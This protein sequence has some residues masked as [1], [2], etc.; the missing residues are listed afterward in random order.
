VTDSPQAEPTGS[1][2][3]GYWAGHFV[4]VASMIG[5]GILTTSGFTLHDT[6]NPAALLAIWVLGGLLALCGGVTV[7]ELA[8]ALP[9]SGGDYVFVREG[10]GRAAAFV[11]GWAT[12]IIGFAAPTALVAH[13]AIGYLTSPFMQP[14][15]DAI[16]QR[17]EVISETV[18]AVGATLLIFGVAAIHTLGHRHSA[19]F[20]VTATCIKVAI[21]LTLAVGGILIGR[22]DWH[23]FAASQWPRGS[24][25]WSALAVGLIY[26][27]YAYAGWNGAAYLAGEIRNPA[28]LLPRCLLG[29]A[30]T[31]IA[32]YLLVNLM[33]VYALDPAAMTS[34]S[35]TNPEQAD[36]IKRVA[37]TATVAMFGRDV[38]NVFT[39]IIGASLVASVSAY[40]LTGPRVAFAMARDGVFPGYA[41]RL[42]PT[43]ETPALATWTQA[44]L[45]TLFLWSGTFK[46]LLDYTA[47]GLAVAAGL[48][49]A[50]IFPIRRRADL[51]HPFRMPLYP[52]PPLAFLILTAWTVGYTL[53]KEV[54]LDDTKF[55]GPAVLSLVTLALGLPLSLLFR[56][57]Q[58]PGNGDSA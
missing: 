1:R 28:K 52:L 47:V 18:I 9:R 22:G 23:H 42:H 36:Q 19:R 49:V 55:P 15:A 34:L 27:G 41:G 48:T 2:K 40:V 16:G 20:Q 6:G 31:V 11:S 12:F 3:F 38:A 21:L 17:P 7:A 24:G 10:Y 25:E 14:L 32:L 39:V 58:S 46:Q 33:Y 56:P 5:A 43:R 13:Q 37:E 4:V 35:Y 8:T 54:V 50:S 30:L 26:V 29:G 51:P 53:Y 44:A 57:P 45:V